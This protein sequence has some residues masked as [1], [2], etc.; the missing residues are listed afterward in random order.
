MEWAWLLLGGQERA[1]WGD[2][3]LT[4][5]KF[6]KTV[7]LLLQIHLLLPVGESK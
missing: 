1:N 3:S 5:P 6:T 7:Q 4:T 2:R